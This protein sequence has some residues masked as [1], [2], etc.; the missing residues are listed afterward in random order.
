MKLFG[1]SEAKI[2]ESLNLF[3]REIIEATLKKYGS[4]IEQGKFDN[5]TVIK[6]KAGMFLAKMKETG[7]RLGRQLNF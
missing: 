3:G 7:E 4:Q 6:S 2:R 1:L 5:G